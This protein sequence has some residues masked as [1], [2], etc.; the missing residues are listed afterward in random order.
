MPDLLSIQQLGI[1]FI[2]ED[3]MAPGVEDLSLD[4]RR[5]EIVALVGESGSGK[6]IT[7]LSILQLLPAPPH[8]M[9]RGRSFLRAGTGALSICWGWMQRRFARSA[10]RR[11]R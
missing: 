1:G 2:T 6:S 9:C 8:G 5:G 11:S 10:G 7:A 3:G 4:L